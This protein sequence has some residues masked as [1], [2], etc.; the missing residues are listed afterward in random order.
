MDYNQAVKEKLA[1]QQF[2]ADASFIK[3]PLFT[4]LQNHPFQQSFII[5][6]TFEHRKF[7][8]W[9]YNKKVGTLTIPRG[10]CEVCNKLEIEHNA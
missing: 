2:Q 7:L 9:K 8:L 6:D 5:Q 1:R 10:L 3:Q 4:P